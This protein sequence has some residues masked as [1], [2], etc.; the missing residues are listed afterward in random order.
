MLMSLFLKSLSALAHC[1][2]LS[3]GRCLQMRNWG[4]ISVLVF[5]VFNSLT[6]AR[7]CLRGRLKERTPNSA[8]VGL[9]DV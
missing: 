5:W 3:P 7:Q 9:L 1:G 6:N 8:D 4:T 2:G